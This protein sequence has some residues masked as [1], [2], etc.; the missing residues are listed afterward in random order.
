L[1]RLNLFEFRCRGVR[2]DWVLRLIKGLNVGSLK[3]V[4]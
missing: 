3:S 2:F 4:Y 1:G